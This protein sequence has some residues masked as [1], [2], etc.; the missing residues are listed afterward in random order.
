MPRALPKPGG[1]RARAYV[2][3][4]P[5]CYA[6]VGQSCMSQG[7]GQWVEPHVARVKAAEAYR[8]P[9][10]SVDLAAQAREAKAAGDALMPAAVPADP[11]AALGTALQELADA[12]LAQARHVVEFTLNHVRARVSGIRLDDATRAWG[13]TTHEG[14]RRADILG[15]EIKASLDAVDVAQ[16]AQAAL[17]AS[18]RPWVPPPQVPDR[19]SSPVGSPTP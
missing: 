3:A 7:G 12:A 18:V 19:V 15:D 11:T 9:F 17:T 13:V 10:A 4:C 16:V 6:Q 14:A 5:F 8:S 2:V 1:I